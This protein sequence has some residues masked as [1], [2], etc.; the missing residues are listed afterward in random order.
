ML[1]HGWRKYNWPEVWVEEKGSK[2]FDFA[3]GL[4]ISGKASSSSNRPLSNASLNVIAQSKERLVCFR[5]V[6]HLMARFRY[7]TSIL[8]G[9]RKLSSTL[10]TQRINLWT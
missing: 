2:E 1:T 3:E 8:T 4:L 7:P 5:P 6:R 10:L 9:Q